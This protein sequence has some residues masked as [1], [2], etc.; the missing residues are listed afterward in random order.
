VLAAENTVKQLSGIR[1]DMIPDDVR[2]STEPLILKGLVADWPCVQ[3]G[4]A[5]CAGTLAYLRRHCSDQ[6]VVVF[7]GAP[8]IEGRFFYN[9]DLTGFNFDRGSSTFSA[10]LTQFESLGGEAPESSLYIG[11]TSVDTGF[12]GFR[13]ENDIALGDL[14]PLV[15]IW[16]GNKTRIAAHFDNPHNI[17][18]VAAGR[19]RFTLFPPDQLA[20]L[21]IGPLDFTPAGQA[22]SLVDFHQPDHVRYPRFKEALKMAQVADLEAGD[23][24]Y[25]PSLWWHHVESLGPFNVLINYWWRSVPAVMGTPMDV[26]IHALLSIKGLPVEQKQAWR[27]ILEHYI[28]S[29]DPTAFSH[30]PQDSLGILDSLDETTAKQLRAMLRSKLGK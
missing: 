11:S 6:E 27:G 8:E 26:L 16:M 28:F 12:P 10:M 3:A 13:Q 14:N 24:L 1:P 9:E 7:K 20:N 17:A 2:N 19:R 23:A 18:C 4:Q 15:S 25:I 30:I 29:E 21:Y 22:I 5:G